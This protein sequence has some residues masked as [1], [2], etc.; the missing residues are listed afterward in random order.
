MYLR[1]TVETLQRRIQRR[2]RDYE[3]QISPEYLGQLNELYEDW[4]DN[5]NLCP[6][7]TIPVDD[8]NYVK[9]PVHLEMVIQKVE[10]KLTGKD[11]VVFD[12]VEV[13]NGRNST[14]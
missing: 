14:Y 6:V 13:A 10:E 11:V 12:P 4:V 1:A 7:L 5:F 8:I 9:H 2:G 3:S